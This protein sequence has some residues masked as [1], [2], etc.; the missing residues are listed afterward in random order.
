MKIKIHAISAFIAFL[1]IALFFISTVL[2][3]LTGD[4]SSIYFV[5]RGIVFGLFVLIPSMMVAGISGNLI[6]KNKKGKLIRKKLNR[7]KIIVFNGVVILVPCAFFLESMA[8]SGNFDEWFFGIQGLE[9][10]AGAI[11]LILIGS[12]IKDG[13]LL[14]GR[15]RK[16][17]SVS[18]TASN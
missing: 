18:N 10:A 14:S 17:K 5:K 11:N 8:G 15:L 12:N 6:T 16:T 13:F 2:V 7:L 3:E 1:T 4:H 9:L